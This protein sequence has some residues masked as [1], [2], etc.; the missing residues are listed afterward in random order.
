MD[1]LEET[2]RE[3]VEFVHLNINESVGK[4][5]AHR[6]QLEAVPFYILYDGEGKETWR[7]SGHILPTLALMDVVKSLNL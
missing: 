7:S 1:R 5:F 3:R 6:V 2:L 4:A